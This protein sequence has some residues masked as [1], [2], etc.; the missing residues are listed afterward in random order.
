MV[1]DHLL[2]GALVGVLITMAQLATAP[3][4]WTALGSYALAG[5]LAL[6]TS[7]LVS[8]TVQRLR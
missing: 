1:I 6:L 8:A 2:V 7:A 4:P 5:S 3:Q